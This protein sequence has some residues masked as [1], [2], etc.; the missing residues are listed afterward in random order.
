MRVS[1]RDEDVPE[2][3]TEKPVRVVVSYCFMGKGRSSVL[4]VAQVPA[5]FELFFSFNPRTREGATSPTRKPVKGN[6]RFNPRTREGAT[7]PSASLMDRAFQRQN[8]RT[9]SFLRSNGTIFSNRPNF[10]F[11]FN[12]LAMRASPWEKS[13]HLG[14]SFFSSFLLSFRLTPFYCYFKR[15]AA[16]PDQG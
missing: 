16:P 3:V 1:D 4:R 9:S 7:E 14:F 10:F 12:D 2:I 15:L 11:L 6:L 13:V 8:S 5:D